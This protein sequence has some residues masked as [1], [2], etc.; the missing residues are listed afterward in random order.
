MAAST[1]TSLIEVIL[2][3]ARLAQE[4]PDVLRALSDLAGT[5]DVNE[6]RRMNLEVDEGGIDPSMVANAY[7]TELATRQSSPL[8]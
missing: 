1:G 5:I 4:R 6:M 2:A 7:L 8:R 3:S